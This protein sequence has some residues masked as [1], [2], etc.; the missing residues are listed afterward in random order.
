MPD[1]VNISVS[2]HDAATAWLWVQLEALHRTFLFFYK[3]ICVA[4]ISKIRILCT[5]WSWS[6]PNLLETLKNPTIAVQLR[7]FCGVLIAAFFIPVSFEMPAFLSFS[8]QL[9]MFEVTAKK[10][11]NAQRAERTWKYI[12]LHTYHREHATP[13]RILFL[14][15]PF[16]RSWLS[17]LFVRCV[18][19]FV[20]HVHTFGRHSSLYIPILLRSA[21]QF[22]TFS[23]VFKSVACCWN[24][25]Q[26]KCDKTV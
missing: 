2:Q 3:W 10:K 1:S 16:S 15:L 12:S 21:I 7:L 19:R 26:M 14:L 6:A 22:S 20:L 5:K 23:G 13:L 11:T 25:Y 17:Y 8:P 4:L 24:W 18:Y 9:K